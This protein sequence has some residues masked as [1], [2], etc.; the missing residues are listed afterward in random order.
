MFRHALASCG[1]DFPD[2]YSK[3]I[4]FCLVDLKGHPLY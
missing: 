3:V 1:D 4:D 2:H